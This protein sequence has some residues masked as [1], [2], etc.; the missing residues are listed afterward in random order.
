[1][2][3]PKRTR[4]QKAVWLQ[5]RDIPEPP[6]SFRKNVLNYPKA[7][8]A[9]ASVAG[10]RLN[11]ELFW[12]M[13]WEFGCRKDDGESEASR[14]YSLSGVALH[15]LRRLPNRVRGWAAE[16]EG[17]ER[18]I[19]SNRAYGHSHASLA[20]F[21]ESQVGNT[22]ASG[23]PKN[24]A[25]SI[26]KSRADLPKLTE[27]P[28]LLRLYADQLEAVCK[29]TARHAPKAPARFKANLEFALIE[30]VKL[31]TGRPHTPEIATLL[32]GAYHAQGSNEIVDAHNLTMR[33]NRH[34]RR[35]Q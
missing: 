21:L 33:Y 15:T 35:R 23:V 11:E 17:L 3:A 4:Q 5:P 31:M 16:I 28:S 22:S 29:F 32:T 19:R 14:W 10:A 25:R 24:L 27:L 12:K 18:Q 20:Q 13:L 7:R 9:F 34:S 8:L 26:L 30:Y 6:A 2:S 1:M